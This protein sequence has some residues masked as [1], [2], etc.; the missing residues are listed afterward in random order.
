MV[1]TGQRIHPQRRQ[2]W[3]KPSVA[4]DLRCA[5][6]GRDLRFALGSLFFADLTQTLSIVRSDL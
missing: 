2:Y 4:I 5:Q 6:G 3:L 1:L